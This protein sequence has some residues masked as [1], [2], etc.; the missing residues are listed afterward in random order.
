MT[1]SSLSISA[2]TERSGRS[3]RS[4]A[5]RAWNWRLYSTTGRHV[6]GPTPSEPTVAQPLRKVVAIARTASR[7]LQRPAL[8]VQGVDRLLGADHHRFA[9]SAASLTA[10]LNAQGKGAAAP[11]NYAQVRFRRRPG[12]LRSRRFSTASGPRPRPVPALVLPVEPPR[13]KP[14][15]STATGSGGLSAA[16]SPG[17]P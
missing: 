15:R 11:V 3:T 1:A 12:K 14:G 17:L 10:R 4:S 16:L 9:A 13:S 8:D 2:I 5:A 7:R 6:P